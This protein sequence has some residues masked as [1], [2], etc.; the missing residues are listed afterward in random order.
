M[1]ETLSRQEWVVMETLWQHSPMFLSEI[2]EAMAA[3]VDWNRSSYL[4]Y[5]K[6]MIDKRLIGYETVRGSRRYYPLIDREEGVEKESR[7]LLSKM[8]EDS[9]RLL[10][11]SM[12]QKSGLNDKDRDDLQALIDKLSSQDRE[13]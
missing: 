7:D 10:L 6:R 1:K 11:A 12:I 13:K 8:T 3:A 5:L 9:T 2:M 4:T